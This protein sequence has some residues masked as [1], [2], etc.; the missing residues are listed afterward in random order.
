[1]SK[2]EP[3][4]IIQGD[5]L[6]WLRQSQD[7]FY[8]DQNNLPVICKASQGWTLT[9]NFAGPAGTIAITASASGDDYLVSV[10]AA[11]TAGYA[12]GL[13]SWAAF[14]TKGANRFQIDSGVST[15]QQNLAT[16]STGY[17][18]R[19]HA[20]QVLDA[21]EAV[22]KNRASTDQQ[23]YQIGGRRLDRMPV[24]DLLKFRNSY[25]REYQRELNAER[26]KNGLAA[27]N[28]VYV[29]F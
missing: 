4:V 19:S 29:R 23:A 13:Y 16:A 15:V 3:D 22:I 10:A 24:A 28:T 2:L 26:I 21:I 14:I 27:K 17:D 12:I 9:Y 1:M 6:S 20:K 8:F 5:T 18:G 11:T 25:Q 7:V